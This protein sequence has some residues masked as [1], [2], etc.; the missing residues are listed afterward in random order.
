MSTEHL[1]TEHLSQKQ[2]LLDNIAI[3]RRIQKLRLYGM[4]ESQLGALELVSFSKLTQEE[5]AGKLD[6]SCR[7][8]ANIEAGN[9]GLTMEN[10]LKIAELFQVSLDYI[11]TGKIENSYTDP[12][13]QWVLNALNHIE[14]EQRKEFYINTI[15]NLSQL[16][17]D[18]QK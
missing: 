15:V 11:C 14:D 10:A 17:L 12:V 1:S 4:P 18:L 5:L 8:M 6:I 13:S 3:G 2:P 9:R 16:M 7:H